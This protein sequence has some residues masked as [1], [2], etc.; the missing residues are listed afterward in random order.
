MTV[1]S[2]SP[3]TDLD[4][5]AALKRTVLETVRAQ[6]AGGRLPD[7]LPLMRIGVEPPRDPAHGDAACNIAMVL[8]KPAGRKPMELAETF[9]DA[10]RA[11]DHVERV[12][13]ARPGFINIRFADGAWQRQVVSILLAGE[14]YG[15]SDL[16]AGERVNVEFC[17]ANP[18][19]P[20]HVGHVRGTIF[21]D[22]TANLLAFT[23]HEVCKEYYINDAGA[24]IDQLARSLHLR[25]REALGEA[26]D[27]IPEGLYPGAYLKPVGKALAERDGDLWL[28]LPESEWLGP[29]RAFA[30][31]AMLALIKDDLA[32]V[33]VHHDVFTSE[34]GLVRAGAVQAV[35]DEL[36]RRDL[37]YTG[38]LPPPKGKPVEDWEPTPQLLFRASEYGDDIDRPL[39][40][41]NGA[42][43]YFASDTAYHLDKINRGYRRMIDVLGADH[44]GYVKRM[45]AFVRAISDGEAE[46]QAPLCQLVHLMDAGQPLK[47][48]KRAGRIVTLRDVVDE[49]GKDVVRFIMLTRKNDAPLEFDFTKVTEQSREN[50]VF[51]VQYAHAR[52][53]S[54]FRNA[55]ELGMAAPSPDEAQSLVQALMAPPEL[56]VMRQLGA[57]PRTVETAAL[58]QEPHRIAFY[59]YE[60][61]G[62]FHAL[63]NHGKDNP[64]LR[65]LRDDDPSLSRARLA[66]LL[67]TQTVL[68]TGLR[69]LGVT[70]VDELH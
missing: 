15:A 2:S 40:R 44:G 50:P 23:G 53:A 43:T 34:A 37:V 28:N 1:S 13:I 62:V 21:G 22:V 9:A 39:K 66:L 33:G 69:L 38:T 63:W 65:F 25:Y 30:T 51:Y 17:S 54:V 56:D 67:A 41:S 31:D 57:W 59:L 6:Q 60:L 32:A 61:A 47:M 16:G 26:I 12:D 58:Q 52:I 5:F 10:L 36:Q 18:T 14:S 3:A 68:A 35:V 4:P 70:P 24:Q 55:A 27:A 11:L 46:L 8:A 19:G 64:S 45:R 29:L 48:S 42:W 49:V 7:D 20:L